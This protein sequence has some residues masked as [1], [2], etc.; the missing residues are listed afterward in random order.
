MPTYVILYKFTEQGR[1]NARQ[2]VEQAYAVRKRDEERG[3]HIRGIYWTQGS[4]DLVAIV[5]APNEQAIMASLIAI[6]SAGNV[7]SETMR[8]FDEEEMEQ[9]LGLSDEYADLMPRPEEAL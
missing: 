5:D 3:F 1:R 8:A 2:T 9:I 6:G 4:S 7:V